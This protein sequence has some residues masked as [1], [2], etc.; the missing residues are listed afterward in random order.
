MIRWKVLSII[1]TTLSINKYTKKEN[2]NGCRI[3]TWKIKSR[4]LQGMPK[5]EW[6]HYHQPTNQPFSNN[7]TAGGKLVLNFQSSE[8]SNESAKLCNTSHWPILGFAMQAPPA[9]ANCYLFQLTEKYSGY[10]RLWTT[11]LSAKLQCV[12]IPLINWMKSLYV[13]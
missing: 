10:Y 3:N 2:D 6:N 12:S 5:D 8:Q 11:I 7:W 9:A 13:D 1:P 4:E